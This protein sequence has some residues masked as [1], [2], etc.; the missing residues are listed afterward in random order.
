MGRWD[1]GRRWGPLGRYV[2]LATE[3]AGLLAGCLLASFVMGPISAATADCANE[4]LRQ[5]QGATFLRDCR[6][7][8]RVSP[9]DKNGEQIDRDIISDL[10]ATSGAASNGEAIA[11]VSQGRFAEI[12]SG[13][14]YAQYRSG[15]HG[16]GWETRGIAP[17]FAS[18]APLQLASPWIH[19]L[20]DDLSTTVVATNVAL[21]PE[22]A[23]LGDTWGLYLQDNSGGVLTH[24][25]LSEPFSDEQPDNPVTGPTA[26]RFLGASK[27][28][29]HV[30]FLSTGWQLTPDGVD[31]PSALTQSVYEWADGQVRAVS[32]LPDGT[33]VG[34]A[35]GGNS[36]EDPLGEV[37]PGDHMVS[38][39][40]QRIFFRLAFGNNLFV[41]ESGQITRPVSE[42]ERPGDDPSLADQATFYAAKA[43]DGSLALFSSS[44]K[45]TE[46]ATATD[47]ASDLYLWSAEPSGGR[48]LT[49]LTTA[50]TG[51]GGVLGMAAAADDL[52]HVYF[53]AQGT[54]AP[55]AEA[56]APN[57]Y[58]WTPGEG[59]RHVATLGNG[60]ASV[61][62]THRS[63]LAPGAGRYRD[64]RVSDDGQHLLFAS[65]AALTSYDTAGHR[66]IYLYDAQTDELTCVSCN[67][68]ATQSSAD[69]DFFP[70]I[71]TQDILG[72]WAPYRL[73]RNLSA[74]GRRATFE[75]AESL[76]A[77]DVNGQP[78][79][80]QWADGEAGLIS[81][82]RAAEGAK[83][84]DV[85]ADG[86]DVFFTTRER[87]VPADEDRQIDMY[88]ARVGG[89][90][91]VQE[92]P[93]PCEGDACQGPISPPPARAS[94][95]S[96]FLRGD[97]NVAGS[98]P[99]TLSLGRLSGVQLERLARGRRVGLAVR[100]NKAG[101]VS[102][103]GFARLA[104]RARAVISASRRVRGAGRHEV[105]I[106]LSG[107]A[108]SRLSVDRALRVRLRVGFGGV[109]RSQTVR[110]S[111]AKRSTSGR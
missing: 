73:T 74:D 30:V 11:Y 20:S 19:Y 54:L 59:L 27:D 62:S 10:F 66:Q 48:H 100:V 22:A 111:P 24:Q 82:G 34:G 49:D 36:G 39:D 97:D 37:Y 102:V 35:V 50:D 101:V 26:F 98:L 104:G 105:G 93:P 40:G 77:Q 78:D 76:V 63:L 12:E 23:R 65:N 75:T 60:D 84:V 107:A 41:R 103:R 53:V 87:L 92:A 95:G 15:R 70:L 51:G 85:S 25:L 110:L 32:I 68:R 14:P 9:A 99:A 58:L 7:Y 56:G 18:G 33:P 55:G 57:L 67:P 83:L 31:P 71:P 13:P 69:A 81:T 61:W 109:T 52:S 91:F 88:D 3:F 44:V 72:P 46:D 28:M 8:E 4:P 47:G 86:A 17:P 64:A 89:G 79:V 42:T 2:V 80:Y 96:A 94:L 90:F 45:L 29:T 108:R 16:G 106:R 5:A 6:A 43:D 38:D 1:E 21:T